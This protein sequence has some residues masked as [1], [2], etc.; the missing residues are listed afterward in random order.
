MNE[1]LQ[2]S[3][4]LKVAPTQ[5]SRLL[6]DTRWQVQTLLL[7]LQSLSVLDAGVDFAI[8][9]LRSCSGDRDCVKQVHQVDKECSD[10][11]G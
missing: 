6:Q 11:S 4:S 10:P 3:T 7:G 5:S 9:H 1:T 2:Q 8:R